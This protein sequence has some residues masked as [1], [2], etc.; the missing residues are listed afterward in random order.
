M[1]SSRRHQERDNL[2]GGISELSLI[3]LHEN[4]VFNQPNID[5]KLYPHELVATTP[6]K[7]PIRDRRIADPPIGG[8]AQP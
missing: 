5:G 3:D 7:S 2:I 8:R 4:R 6:L 1:W